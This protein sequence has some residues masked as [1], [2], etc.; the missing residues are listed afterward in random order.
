MSD[1]IRLLPDSIA[2]QIAAGE[3]IQRPASIVKELLENAIDAGAAKIE[4]IVKDGGKT[5]VQVIDNGSGMSETDA[6]MC[7]ERHATSKIRQ[8]DDLF[9]I[10][11]M[12][13]RGEAMASIAAVAQVEMKTR[14]ATEELGTMIY[15]EDSTVKSQEPCQS[16]TGTNIA[17]KNLF[18]NVPARRNFLK[19]NEV[20]LRHIHDEFLR[21]A[22]AN[23]GIHFSLHHNDNELYNLYP[24]TLRKRIVNI[25]GANTDKRLIPVSESSEFV[26]VEGFVGKPETSKKTRSEQFFFVNNRYIKNGYLHHAVMTAYEDLIKDDMQPLY[27]LFLEIDPLHIDINVHPTKQEIKFDDEKTIYH[28]LRVAVRHAVGKHHLTP[29]LDFEQDNIF[30]KPPSTAT[31]P[32]QQ[33]RQTGTVQASGFPK[34]N[35]QNPSTALQSDNLKNWRAMFENLEKKPEADLVQPRE[36]VI[37]AGSQWNKPLIEQELDVNQE[38]NGKE[39]YQFHNTYIVSHIR[40]GL[41]VIDQQTAHERILYE[42]FLHHIHQREGIVQKE[43]FP[44]NIHLQAANAEI[45]KAILPEINHVGFE[46]EDMGGGTFAVYGTPAISGSNVNVEDMIDTMIDQYRL[47]LEVKTGIPEAVAISMATNIGIK[48]GM[49]LTKEEMQDIIDKLFA[50]EVS[51]SSPRGKKCFIIIELDEILKRFQ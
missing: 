17:V 32:P 35:Y 30:S 14:R 24:A 27:I 49:P 22:M 13:F 11:T 48:K 6:R 45:L 2:N 31:N 33:V 21:V 46:I 3:V 43:L 40:S 28:H 47:S 10:R 25:F 9:K 29:M 50:C 23:P 5:L 34:T 20:E 51:A 16:P 7:W 4:V 8:A 41:M 18:F 38:K 39:P 12:G 37:T 15:I 36:E 42:Q 44:R 1:I 19:S 26:S